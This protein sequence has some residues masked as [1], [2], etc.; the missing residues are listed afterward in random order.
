MKYFIRKLDKYW[1]KGRM[2]VYVELLFL[3]FYKKKEENRFNNK[4]KL[5]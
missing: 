3:K 5:K 1:G 2:L 4:I